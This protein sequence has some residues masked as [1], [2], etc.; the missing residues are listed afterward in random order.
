MIPIRNVISK[1]KYETALEAINTTYP[2]WKISYPDGRTEYIAKKECKEI[3]DGACTIYPFRYGFIS[4]RLTFPRI[5][6]STDFPIFISAQT[7]TGK[8]QFIFD[9]IYP[10]LHRMHQKLLILVSRSPLKTKVKYD[11]IDAAGTDQRELLTPYGIEKEHHFGDIDVYSYQDFSI[12]DTFNRH[13]QEVNSGNYGA[14]IF[15]ECH[16]FSADSDFNEATEYIFHFLTQMAYR[17]R[18]PRIYMTGT[19]DVVFDRILEREKE[20]FHASFFYMPSRLNL[21]HFKRDYS[22]LQLMTFPNDRDYRSLLKII[23]NEKS[24]KWLI[25]VDSIELGNSLAHKIKELGKH[26]VFLFSKTLH[27]HPKQKSDP[28][29]ENVLKGL[30]DQENMNCDVLIATKC[31]DVGITIKDKNVNIVSFL[32]DKTDFLQSIG[33]KRISGDEHV[34]LLIPEYKS[35]DIKLWL[36]T[37]YSKLAEFNAICQHCPEGHI[38]NGSSFKN[39]VYIEKGTYHHNHFAFRKLYFQ[40]RQL[41]SLITDIEE[42]SLPDTEVIKQ[43][44]ASWMDSCHVY[45][46]P[47][48]EGRSQALHVIIENY[49]LSHLTEQDFQVLAE[50]LKPY[51]VRTDQRTSRNSLSTRSVNTILQEIG[52]KIRKQKKDN[53]VT[54]QIIPL[55][56]EAV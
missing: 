41:E 26:T 5:E 10:Q 35:S 20:L 1:S 31:L 51:D 55:P 16:F 49:L 13:R 7:G 22:Y 8:T 33:R 23:E 3:D 15:D 47:V 42:S 36:S 50:L 54:Y 32:H 2:G 56:K 21:Y 52:Y 45:D 9:V 34:N 4:E 39:P 44:F 27:R 38:A 43:Y 12:E 40:I 24:T 53:T 17:Q 29:I 14:V 37:S 28:E 19:P 6:L 11:A 30:T 18:I 48:A 46:S 25:F